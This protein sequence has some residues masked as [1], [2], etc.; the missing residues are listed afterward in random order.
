MKKL[1]FILMSLATSFTFAQVS[2][3]LGDFDNVR[4]FDRIN[5]ELIPAAEN[6]IEINGKRSE[7]VEVV[8]RNGELK[9]RMK[10]GKLLKGDDITAKLYFKKIEGVDASEGSYIVSDATFK[11]TS[12][13]I[14]AKEGAEIRLSLNVSKAKVKSVTGGIVRIQGSADNQEASLGTGGVLEAADLKTTQ[15]T[16]SITT[17][18]EADVRA[19]ELVDAKVRAGGTITIYGSPKQI[20]KKTVL[21]G[22]IVE[23]K[24]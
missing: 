19:T 12:F 7:E 14:I 16:V 22:D 1:A 6:K 8:N 11:Q 15:T 20:N 3:D 23:S 4:V 17:G 21:G 9:I 18:G 10:F 24:Q 5:V 13:E 2:K